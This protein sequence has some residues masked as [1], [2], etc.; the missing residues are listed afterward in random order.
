[1]RD[2]P[3]RVDLAVVSTPRSEVRGVVRQCIEKGIRA[4]TIVTQGFADANEE[5][6]RMQSELVRMAREGG[7]RIMGPNTFGTCNA[8]TSF[9]SAFTPVEMKQVP[10]GFMCQTG[11]FI[12]GI[13]G[14]AMLGKGID[15][16]NASDIDFADGLEYFEHDPQVKVVFLH[17][18]GLPNGARFMEVARRVSRRKP[19]LALKTGRGEQSAEAMQSHTGTL[20]GS[21][22]V[23]EAAFRQSGVMRVDDIDEFE[24]FTRAYLRVPPMT[25]SGVAVITVAGGA[26]IM[27]IDAAEKYGLR[28]ATLHPDT[29]E[30]IAPLAPPWQA[31]GNPADIW[32]AI[33]I[34]RRRLDEVCYTIADAF[35]ADDAVHGIILVAHAAFVFGAP[36]MFRRANEC[37]KPILCWLYGS[38]MEELIAKA[39]EKGEMAAFPSVDRAV[40]TLARLKQYH[41]FADHHDD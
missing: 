2:V 32:P 31:L 13:P 21:D 9:T 1:M 12:A 6:A 14:F 30:G 24:D 5:G 26:G 34:Q 41:D 18:E 36:D 20:A 16:G 23:Y 4:I 19:I 17:V 37:G 35:L 40:R 8:F 10:I 29:L 22:Q 15:L 11:V 39:E 25:G 7:A 38:R 28:L 27:A 3:E 33:M